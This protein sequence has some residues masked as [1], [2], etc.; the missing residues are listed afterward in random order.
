MSKK[1]KALEGGGGGGEPQLPEEEPT[2]WF[3]G[4]SEE[5]GTS[6]QNAALSP[7]GFPRAHH[8]FFGYLGLCRFVF[9]F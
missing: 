1:R 4:S 7:C 5:P 9:R 8:P 2:A 6:L 3:G